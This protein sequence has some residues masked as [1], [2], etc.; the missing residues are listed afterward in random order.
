MCIA[1]Q[2]DE[3]WIFSCCIA[4]RIN[5]DL[6]VFFQDFGMKTVNPSEGNTVFPVVDFR[7]VLAA[8]DPSKQYETV[9]KR[10]TFIHRQAKF[11]NESIPQRGQ[12]RLYTD[13]F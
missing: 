11:Y 2:Q 1:I 7:F 8:H 4:R 3:Q 13:N 9:K 5:P 6:T 12:Y 10:Y